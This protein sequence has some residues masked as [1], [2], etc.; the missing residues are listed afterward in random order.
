MKSQQKDKQQVN[1]IYESYE[2]SKIKP[3][4]LSKLDYLIIYF[5]F[6]AIQ[7]PEKPEQTRGCVIER[8]KK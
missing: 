5:Y 3:F 4:Y 1:I 6:S 2:N 7:T 8:S